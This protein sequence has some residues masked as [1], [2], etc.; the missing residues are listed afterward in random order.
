MAQTS[1]GKARNQDF[2]RISLAS[3]KLAGW[4]LL[5]VAGC[6]LGLAKPETSTIADR[7][8]L[9]ARQRE[10]NTDLLQPIGPILVAGIGCTA[11]GLVVYCLGI[12][13]RKYALPVSLIV[14]G[15]I[16]VAGLIAYL[17]Y[18]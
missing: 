11:L 8:Y 13:N 10:W 15:L 16:S 1:T 7:I 9:T 2:G 12:R 17:V 18:T 14:T 3:L 4:L 6:L 5:I